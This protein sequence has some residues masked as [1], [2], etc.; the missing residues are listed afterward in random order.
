[1]TRLLRRIFARI[2]RYDAEIRC[3]EQAIASRAID[4]NQRL[5]D[6]RVAVEKV[7]GWHSIL[8]GGDWVELDLE[9][10]DRGMVV[11][12]VRDFLNLLRAI[13]SGAR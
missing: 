4:E 10:K 2:G 5:E 8:D 7:I 3:L 6:C 12:T 9:A 13:H 1:M 11:T